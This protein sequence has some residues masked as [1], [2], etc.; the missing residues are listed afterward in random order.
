M[1]Y[2]IAR[3]ADSDIE[4]ICDRIASNNPDAADRLDEEIHR[5]IELL[6]QFPRMGHDR[7]DVADKR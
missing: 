5:A 1:N 6:A 3:K 4:R 7:A 2:R